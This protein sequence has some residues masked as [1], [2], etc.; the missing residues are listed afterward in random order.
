MGDYYSALQ[1]THLKQIMG[2]TWSLGV[3]E[4]FYLLWRAAAVLFLRNPAK[5]L[6]AALIFIGMIWVYRTITCLTTSLPVDYLR[7]SFESRLDTILYGCAL[8]LATSMFKIEP[9]LRAVERV[10]A[11][12]IFI[13][14]LLVGGALLENRMSLRVYYIVD[15]PLTSLLIAVMLIQLVFLAALRGWSWL[16]HPVFRFLGRISYSLYLYQ[17]IVIATVE[18]YL[19]HLR[20]RWAFPL[21]YVATTLVAYA[22][23]RLVEAPFLRMKRRFEAGAV[24]DTMTTLRS[25]AGTSSA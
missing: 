7:Y 1:P 12:P 11:L 14:A 20:L 24:V 18:H 23:Y 5:L 9:M 15:L 3:E 16:E 8:A 25:A 17:I 13:G 10:K 6:R 4:K 22:S 2:I 21:M 19:P